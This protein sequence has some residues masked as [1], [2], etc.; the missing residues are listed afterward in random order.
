MATTMQEKSQS[1]LGRNTVRIDGPLK[2]TGTAKYTSDFNFPGMLY[3]VPVPSTI[4]HGSIKSLDATTAEKMPGVAAIYHRRNIGQIFR[5]APTQGLDGHLDEHRA[6]LEDDEITYYGQ[7]IAL[8]VADTF[9]HA[10]AAA[11]AID[12]KYDVK[13]LNVSGGT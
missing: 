4:A 6:P 13:T 7:Y 5:T 12:V 1:V 3:A 11:A 9:E 8:V 10:T 2:V